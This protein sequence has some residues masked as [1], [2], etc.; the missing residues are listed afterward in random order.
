MRAVQVKAFGGRENLALVNL[1]KPSPMA[2]EVL[3]RIKAAS[4]NHLDIWVRKGLPGLRVPVPFVPCSD[5]A[6][7]IESVGEGVHLEPGAE[8]VLYPAWFCGECEACLAGR[9]NH[10]RHYSILGESRGGCLAEFV[11][12]PERMVFKKPEGL[13]FEEA[14]SFPLAWLTSWHMMH[15]KAHVQAGDWVLIQA[16]ASGT[17]IAALQ[18]AK[19]F[20]ARVVATSSKLEKLACLEDLGADVVVNYASENLREVVK[21]QTQRHGCDVVIDHVGEATFADSMA[22]LA[23]GGRFVTCGGSSGPMLSFDVRHLFIKHQ[24]ILGST[25]GDTRDFRALLKE[26]RPTRDAGK[27]FPVVDRVLRL[28]DVSEAYRLLEHRELVGKVVISLA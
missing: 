1:P 9:E 20:G 5:G 18:M 23:R 6:G 21:K 7:V 26:V 4:L 25:M 28:E 24:A 10:C 17:G 12:V 27:L 19:H 14:A 22:C 11:V 13:S 3:V 15:Q 2:G 8:V 16:A